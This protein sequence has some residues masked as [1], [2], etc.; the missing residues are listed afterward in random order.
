MRG[1]EQI[2]VVLTDVD[3]SGGSFECGRVVD[4]IVKMVLNHCD[5]VTGRLGTGK[6]TENL[7]RD[8]HL[9]LHQVP[10]L[11]LLCAKSLCGLAASINVVV[12]SNVNLAKLQHR[13]EQFF[14]SGP[15]L[16]VDLFRVFADV[17]RH[18]RHRFRDEFGIIFH[19]TAVD[20]IRRRWRGLVGGSSTFRLVRGT[21][22]TGW[23]G[24]RLADQAGLA[25]QAQSGD[26]QHG[27]LSEHGRR[28]ART[29][30]KWVR[31]SEHAKSRG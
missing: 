8:L 28:S 23:L 12:E 4:V 17:F 1:E 24:E 6:Q 13:F 31:E 9:F 10:C 19:P 21:I 15:E 25:S 14:M 22:R 16:R 18:F 7:D 3:Q 2:A 27:G 20:S 26:Q 30:K 5:H 11:V 29:S